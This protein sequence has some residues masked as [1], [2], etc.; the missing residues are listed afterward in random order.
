MKTALF[1]CIEFIFFS[2]KW[3]LWLC[4]VIVFLSAII[5]LFTPIKDMFSSSGAVI[6]ISGFLLGI[7]YTMVFPLEKSYQLQVCTIFMQENVRLV[8]TLPMNKKKKL[9]RECVM[10]NLVLHL[11]SLAH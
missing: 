10:R 11:W 2:R 7:K 4:I 3:S 8:Q 6:A 5:D 1:A 9:E